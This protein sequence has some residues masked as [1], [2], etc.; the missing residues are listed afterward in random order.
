[1]QPAD[2]FGGDF[3]GYNSRHSWEKKRALN[4]VGRREDSFPTL[5]LPNNLEMSVG[6]ASCHR[7]YESGS[8]RLPDYM[9]KSLVWPIL[10]SNPLR[11]LR[12]KYPQGGKK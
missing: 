6:Q 2:V 10:L 5:E 11:W 9:S 8:L 3:R 7:Y 12:A 4:T 1:M